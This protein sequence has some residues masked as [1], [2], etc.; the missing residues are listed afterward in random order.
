MNQEDIK[1]AILET[2][3]DMVKAMPIQDFKKFIKL[4]KNYSTVEFQSEQVLLDLLEIVTGPGGCEEKE[5]IILKELE[6]TKN[7]ERLLKEK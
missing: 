3:F 6:K 1:K 4:D 5:Y 2:M 7:N